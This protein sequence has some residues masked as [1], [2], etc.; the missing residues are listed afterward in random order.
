MCNSGSGTSI[1]C[2]H[3]YLFAEECVSHGQLSPLACLTTLTL[4]AKNKLPP[5]VEGQ[6]NPIQIPPGQSIT[7]RVVADN[8]GAWLLRCTVSTF[9]FISLR[10]MYKIKSNRLLFT[11]TGHIEWH[12]EV[13]LTMQFIEAPLQLQQQDTTRHV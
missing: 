9:Y 1:G 10:V 3:W 5:V 4:A 2:G 11:V 8:P 12:L 13:G 7:L 6:A